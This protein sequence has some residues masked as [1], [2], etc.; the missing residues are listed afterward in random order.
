[1]R[2]HDAE[3]G[4]DQQQTQQAEKTVTLENFKDALK[5]SCKIIISDNL[6]PESMNKDVQNF[7]NGI[8]TLEC[9]KLLII[10]NSL[11]FKDKEKFYEKFYLEVVSKSEEHFPGLL[12][13]SSMNICR[14]L[15]EFM[16]SLHKKNREID[17]NII[18]KSISDRELAGL[19]YLSG[20]VIHK[21]FSKERNSKN[22][23][24][25][26][27]QEA[28]TILQAARSTVSNENATLVEALSRGGLWSV[29]THAQAIFVIAEKIFCIKTNEKQRTVNIFA[30]VKAVMEFSHVIENYKAILSACDMEISKE[31]SKIVLYNMISLYM[32]VRAFSFAKDIVQKHKI[33][34]K[35][36][37]KVSSL[38]KTLKNSSDNDRK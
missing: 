36:V 29:S 33:D 18:T 19:Q 35:K 11:N 7:L 32:R 38:R 12:Y 24:S 16:F 34:Q 3:E 17:S 2:K 21:L 30:M 6:F 14:K 31:V 20:Y 10:S 22:Y 9:N 4:F 26:E 13:H 25:A 28:M 37:G 27:S 5:S 15:G 1:M 8:D 23:K